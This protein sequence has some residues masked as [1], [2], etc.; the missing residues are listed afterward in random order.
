MPDDDDIALSEKRMYGERREATRA[1]LASGMGV[2]YVDASDD[3]VGRFGLERRCTAR[4][5]A[6][7]D[8]HL[9]VA[10]DEDVLV[11]DEGAFDPAGFGP[12][13]AVG[14]GP[15]LLAAAEDGRVAALDQGDWE[16]LGDVGDV[17][18]IDGNLV[19][20]ADGV[21]RR[22]DGLEPAGLDDVRDVA[23]P[24]PFAATA[25][26]VY[27]FDDG[28]E[29]EVTGDATV[30]SSDGERAHAVVDGTLLERDAGEW[31]DAGAPAGEVVDVAYDRATFAVT[32]DGRVLLD[33]VTAKDGAP[34]W[35]TRSL[36]LADVVG[37][38]IP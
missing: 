24:G 14:V 16:T 32:A 21:Y 5:V 6:G 23:T 11:G 13:V 36:G 25:D 3:Q 34:E 4:D 37:V 17:R 2:A 33:P 28:W 9:L 31:R 35:R 8:G 20:T 18:A 29:L 27:R 22:D 10:T 7:A 30:V 12:A 26:G 15:T 1:Y 19:A 38:A